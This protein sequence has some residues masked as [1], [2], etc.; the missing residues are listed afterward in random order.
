MSF[1]D[2][3]PPWTCAGCERVLA[4]WPSATGTMGELYCARCVTLP[5]EFVPPKGEDGSC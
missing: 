4:G 1:V 5:E 2:K 3:A